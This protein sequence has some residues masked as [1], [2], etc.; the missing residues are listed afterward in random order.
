MSVDMF[1]WRFLKEIKKLPEFVPNDERNPRVWRADFPAWHALFSS[2]CL[3]GHSTGYRLPSFDS[4]FD[5]CRKAYTVAHS[6]K[7]KYKRFFED[8]ELVPGM[9]QR[10]SAWYESGM[11]ELYLYVCLV[12]AIED[13][14]KNGIVVYDP[15]ADW[16]LKADAIVIVNDKPLRISA[17]IGSNENRPK[18]EASRDQVE[19]YRKRNTKDSAHWD[20]AQLDTMLTLSITQDERNQQIVNGL[21][22]FSIASI[23]SLLREIYDICA[24]NQSRFFF[25][26][27]A[28][29][30]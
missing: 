1:E 10:I 3:Y 21:R 16:K 14:M 22:M 24:V 18:V 5:Y 25:D 29:Q 4:F 15:R 26:N 28:N 13:K 6:D 2:L 11:S 20:N 30:G 8:K 27:N 7:D 9:R 19:R 23:N 17:F 12:E